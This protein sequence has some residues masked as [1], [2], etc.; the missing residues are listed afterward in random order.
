V[1]V[2]V[3]EPLAMEGDEEPAHFAHR[4]QKALEAL[5]GSG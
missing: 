5:S 1:A 2:R 4:L 3:G